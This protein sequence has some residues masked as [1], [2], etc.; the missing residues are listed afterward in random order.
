MHMNRK[1]KSHTSFLS[2]V[3][4]YGASD[5]ANRSTEQVDRSSMAKMCQDDRVPGH[6]FRPLSH[7]SRHIDGRKLWLLLRRAAGAREAS[8]PCRMT[9]M[10]WKRR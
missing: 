9:C 10:D 8:G 7:L 1:I 4:M 3:D 5:L 2:S 6:R